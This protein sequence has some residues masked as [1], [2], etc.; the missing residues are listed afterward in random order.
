VQELLARGLSRA[1]VSRELNHDIQK[2][3]RFANATCA[4]ELLGNA[5][6]RLSKL[7]LYLDLVNQ[8][9]NEGTNGEAITAEL[10]TLGFR[11]DAQAVHRYLQPF[12]LP[13]ES[14][15]HHDPN[16]RKP[17]HHQQGAAHPPRPSNR[18]RREDPEER[19]RRMRPPRTPPAARRSFAKI[20]A[21]RRGRELPA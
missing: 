17:P 21:Q 6:H 12:R 7:D 18:G 20:M 5:E 11:G 9:W 1:A 3:R 8:R 10:R 14:R 19:H 13:G 2:V 16:R 4:E 15:S